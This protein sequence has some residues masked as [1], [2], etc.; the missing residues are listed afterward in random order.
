MHGVSAHTRFPRTLT[1]TSYISAVLSTLN[2][3]LSVTN[4]SRLDYAET[5]RARKPRAYEY[6]VLATNLLLLSYRSQ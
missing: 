1:I 2:P 5:Q 6:V 3:I 4:L